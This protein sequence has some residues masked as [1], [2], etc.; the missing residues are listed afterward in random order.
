MIKLNKIFLTLIL[1]MVFSCC[2][3]AVFASFEITEIMYD[4]DGTDTDREWIEVENTGQE[5]ID[6][7]KWYL[8]SDNS[9]H[10]L[11][12]QGESIVPVGGYAV[13][14]QNIPKFRIDWPN[15]SGLLFDSSW[16]GLNN[17]SDEISL[18]DPDLNI[19]SPII[20]NSSMG[21]SGNGD[22]L[23]II[24]GSWQGASPTPGLI[25][26]ESQSSTNPNSDSITNANNN[27]SS[28]GSSVGSSSNSISQIKKEPENTKITTKILTNNIVTAG[29]SFPV[30]EQ[31]IGYKKEKIV[32]GKFVWNFGDG[33]T[34]EGTTSPPFEYTY[35]YPGDYALTLS[36]YS[37]V[38][39]TKPIA[40][41][42]MI[43][44]VIPSGINIT[45]IGDQ[46]DPFVEIE[47]NSS[48]EIALFKWKIIGTSHFFV[49]PEGMIILPK[50][51]LKLSPKITGFNYNDFS[52]IIIVDSYGQ[53][54]ATYP[55]KNLPPVKSTS[56]EIYK[57]DVIK[58]TS[59]KIKKVE[60]I[61]EVI[62][63]NNLGS[64][65]ESSDS[66]LDNKTLIYLGLF[67]ILLLGII[68]VFIIRRKNTYPDYIEK[69]ISAK[70]ITII[71]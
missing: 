60:D 45:S 3:R 36:F 28:Y 50:K 43:I 13:I 17:E 67:G 26:Q 16:T 22:S 24:G 64:S 5:S 41:D 9:K 65:A 19:I 52:S 34:R 49:I 12:A 55:N 70:D 46:S 44:K 69:E 20:F 58:S 40:I 7:S 54:F 63:L 68:S 1:I 35:Q 4:L 10:T 25:N 42:K 38:F 59:T 39:D 48:Y 31:T 18:K 29:V 2:S 56:N 11:V 27:S 8:F 51:K 23:Q 6:L 14:A 62:N 15:Y 47:N 21:G 57:G 30:D 66:G 61:P 53:I 33:M 37:S 32:F 71:E